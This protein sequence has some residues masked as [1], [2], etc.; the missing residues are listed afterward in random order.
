MKNDQKQSKLVYHVWASYLSVSL[1]NLRFSCL[2]Y[3]AFFGDTTWTIL[4]LNNWSLSRQPHVVLKI[5]GNTTYRVLSYWMRLKKKLSSFKESL[6]G[7]E[8]YR[9]WETGGSTIKVFPKQ[10]KIHSGT[11]GTMDLPISIITFVVA[12]A[13]ALIPPSSDRHGL[14][15][16]YESHISTSARIGFNRSSM[17]SNDSEPY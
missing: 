9:S 17:K 16:W 14:R 3:L 4:F 1:C 12:C 11:T 13:V 6:V 7:F 15:S 5:S 8:R 10:T 2:Y